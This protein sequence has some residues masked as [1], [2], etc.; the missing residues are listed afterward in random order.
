MFLQG[1]EY[2]AAVAQSIAEDNARAGPVFVSGAT[3]SSASV[4]NGYYEPTEEK[5]ADGRVMYAKRG[6][7]SVCIEHFKEE[8]GVKN[9]S[10]KNSNRCS[11]HV[12]GGSAFDSCASR[13]WKVYDYSGTKWVEQPSVKM[14]TGAEAERQ[15]SVL[16]SH[17]R[18]RT[19]RRVATRTGA[20]ALFLSHA[21]LVCFR[22]MLTMFLPLRRALPRTTHELGRC[23]SLARR[24]LRLRF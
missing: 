5:G 17:A 3:G 7:G 14:V 9:N 12:S 10:N 22:W 11:A 1:A 6:D 18:W 23:S 2:A 21:L 16:L 24:A 4:L 19:T 13:V 15:V 20:A 8:W